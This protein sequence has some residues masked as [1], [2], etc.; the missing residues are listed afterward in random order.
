M[1][2]VLATLA[3]C[4]PGTAFASCLVPQDSFTCQISKGRELSV[5]AGTEA[6]TYSFG[7]GE[8][9]EIELTVDFADAEVF[10]WAGLGHSIW[11]SIIFRR[12]AHSYEVFVSQER[13]SDAEPEGGVIVH[14]DD[15]PIAQLDCLPGTVEASPD[16][17]GDVMSARGFCWNG[18]ASLWQMQGS[19]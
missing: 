12:G 16:V 15:K 19:C 7:A 8:P 4:L 2:L 14:K 17:F 3:L 18:N 1:R 6:F 10:P 13:N 9:P 11:S 5:C